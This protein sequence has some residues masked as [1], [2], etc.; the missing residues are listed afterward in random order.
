MVCSMPIVASPNHHPTAACNVS[1][2]EREI[3]IQAPINRPAIPSP[4]ST[5]EPPPPLSLFPRTHPECVLKPDRCE[6]DDGVS[7]LDRQVDE[8]RRPPEQRVLLHAPRLEPLRHAPCTQH[9]RP[10]VTLSAPETDWTPAHIRPVGSN[11][12]LGLMPSSPLDSSQGVPP[13]SDPPYLTTRSPDRTGPGD[14]FPVVPSTPT[15]P[16]RR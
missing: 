10:Q 11:Q 2:A 8:G 3:I 14:R 13:A 4:F 7:V 15:D 6:G 12:P 1:P 16:G 9:K 5:Y